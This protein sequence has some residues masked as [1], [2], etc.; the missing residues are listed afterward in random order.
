MRVH[1]AKGLLSYVILLQICILISRPKP[2]CQFALL[3][4]NQ[5]TSMSVKVSLLFT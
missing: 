3:N 2:A 4:E 1:Y 5:I